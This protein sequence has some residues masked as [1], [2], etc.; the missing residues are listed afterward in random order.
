[1]RFLRAA[2]PDCSV[3]LASV[4]ARAWHRRTLQRAAYPQVSN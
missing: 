3:Y 4:V 1:M 2:G